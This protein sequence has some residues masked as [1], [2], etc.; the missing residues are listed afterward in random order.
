MSDLLEAAAAALGTPAELVRRSAA[1][2]AEETGSSIDDVLTAWAGGAPV[3]APASA[4]ASEAP[5]EA[6]AAE[7]QAAA[8]AVE[9]APLIEIP[10]V[11]EPE[12]EAEPVEPLKPAALGARVKTAVRIGSWTGAALG[13]AGFLIATSFWA[14]DTALDPDG[15]PVVAVGTQGLLVGSILVSIFFGSIVAG[16]SRAGTAWSNPSMQLASSP[17]STVWLGGALGLVMGVVGGALLL[18]LG[19]PIEAVEGMTQVP[20]LPTLFVLVAGG[21]ALGAATSAVPQLLGTPVAVDE[22]DADEV[23]TVRKRLGDAMSIPLAG[24]VILLL[25]VLPFAYT[26]IE[27][28]HMTSGG[29][30]VVAIITASGILAFAALSGNKPDV[31]IS[32]GELMIALAGIGTVLMIIVAVLFYTGAD[33]HGADEG[34]QASALEMTI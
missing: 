29:A 2:R 6:A 28:N 31:K 9:E 16:L 25:L 22:L 30:S 4:P 8:I 19:T 26:L 13:I 20:I 10:V 17:T 3:A 1:A 12:Y 24:L 32:F 7:P 5:A 27:S 18:G 21:A 14:S 34:D 23:T 33:D 11:V 15:G